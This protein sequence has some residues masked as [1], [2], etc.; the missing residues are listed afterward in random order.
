MPTTLKFGKLFGKSPFKPMKEHMRIANECA[1]HMPEATK[2]FLENDKETL[3][4][5]KRSVSKLE[6]EADKVLEELQ[7]RLSK[8]MFLPVER[9]DLLD[10]LEVQEAIADRSEEIVQLMLDLPIEVPQ[11]MHKPIMSL[12]ARAEDTV[13]AA[14][15]VVGMFDDLVE[16]GFKG[17]V[18]KKT[19]RMIRDVIQLE[20]DADHIGTDITHALFK[21][22]GDMHPVSIV[23]LYRLVNLIEDLADYAESVAIRSRLLLAG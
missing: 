5:I 7:H 3:K 10:V 14:N 22:A 2:A 1:S 23:F 21:H 13:S 18:V 19:R 12:A 4:E 9:R 16:V 8:S 15:D 20:S 17:P 11:E 6:S